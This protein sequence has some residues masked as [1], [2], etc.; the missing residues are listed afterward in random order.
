MHKLI[1]LEKI[2]ANPFRRMEKYPV[3]E[4]KIA[5]LMGSMERTGFWENV[6]GREQNGHV[7]LAYGHHR[8]V[9]FK[10]KYGKNASMNLIIRKISDEDMLRVMA[11]E[12]A[13]EFKFDAA[14]EME[15]IR[16]VV[17]AWA[18]GEIQ[19]PKVKPRTPPEKI[20]YAPSFVR[21]LTSVTN[22]EVGYTADSI[23]EFLGWKQPNGEPSRRILNALDALEA[24]EK[25]L[26]SESELAGLG[27]DQAQVVAAGA[28]AI[29]RSYEQ[30]GNAS[31]DS[32]HKERMKTKGRE[33]AKSAAKRA[34]EVLKK[35]K[36]GIR[37]VRETMSLARAPKHP[38]KKVPDIEKFVSTLTKDLDSVLGPKDV[39][40]S[41]IKEVVKFK[42]DIESRIKKNLVV[43]L[44]ELSE[45]CEQLISSLGE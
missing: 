14:V 12:N 39:R 6:V 35:K 2:V 24:A 17:E 40:R 45:R 10:K 5:A 34:I 11:D 37:D 33:V 42:D 25:D 41:K 3:R 30:A 36:G 9:A 21:G 16:A 20:R 28:A 23:A 13:E 31:G 18:K 7:Q 32:E 8:W 27:S 22:T 19:L 26:V 1:P 43:A 38:E 44:R 15:T 4:E 29:E